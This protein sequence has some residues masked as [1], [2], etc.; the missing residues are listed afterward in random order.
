MF[1]KAAKPLPN[2]D[3]V[4][5]RRVASRIQNPTNYFQGV[6]MPSG[7][8]PEKILCFVR[9]RAEALQHTPYQQPEQHHRC[10]L[11]I[12]ASGSGRLCLDAD[13]VALNEGQVLLIAPFQFH[14]YFMEERPEPICWIFLTFEIRSMGEIEPLRSSSP[15]TLG[16]T[17][18]MLLREI[19]Q[20]WLDPKRHA[21][22]S[23]HLGLFLA[24]LAAMKAPASKRSQKS[25]SGTAADWI[26][27]V[28]SRVLP[29]LDRPLNV[30][31]LAQELGNSESH[32][33]AKFRRITGHS[34]GRHLR[35]LRIQKACS[36]LQSTAL[37]VGEI[38]EQCGF[39][40]VYSFSRTFKVECGVSPRAYRQGSAQ[41]I[42]I[43]RLPAR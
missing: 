16:P 28:N 18:W 20:C 26:A 27:R 37:S 9:H 14:S 30:K 36:L 6:N 5:I 33:R 34:L 35:H 12:A 21:L 19:L 40:S 8:L 31:Q 38:A 17:E 4:E 32:L 10:V 3:L 22:L 43:S 23:L 39:D 15:R 13:H 2:P 1:S 42:S 24:R 29:R 11:V 7:A 25:P 41:G